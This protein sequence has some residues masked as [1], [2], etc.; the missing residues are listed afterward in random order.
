[1]AEEHGGTEFH[2]GQEVETY[3]AAGSE[4]HLSGPYPPTGLHLPIMPSYGEA[5][6]RLRLLSV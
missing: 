5:T 4:E 1:M 2:C 6:S 3:I